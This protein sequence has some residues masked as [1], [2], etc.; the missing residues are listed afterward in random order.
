MDEERGLGNRQRTKKQPV[1][2]VHLLT[3]G[4][5]HH[6]CDGKNTTA[7]GLGCTLPKPRGPEE[8]VPPA[9]GR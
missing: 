9:D 2:N 1:F 7:H 8:Q 3:L 5:I 4:T 6:A